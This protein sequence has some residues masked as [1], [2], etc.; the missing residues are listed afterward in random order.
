M[1]GADPAEV[2]VAIHAQRGARRLLLCCDFDGTLVEFQPDPAAVWLPEERRALLQR[3]VDHP[4]V[5]VGIIS[6]RRLA[7]IRERTGLGEP[8]WFAGLH[9]LE[10][11]GGGERFVHPQVAGA[12]ALVQGLS[13]ALS[14]RVTGKPGA[15]I[16]DKDLSVA[17]HFR[18]SPPEIQAEVSAAFEQLTRPAIETGRLRVMRG[19]SV[20]E[21]LPNIPWNKGD[22]VRWI[23]A[24]V[25]RRE[26]GSI[27]PVYFGD[28]VTDQ[29]AFR[30]LEGRGVRIAA[31]DRVSGGDFTVDGPEGITAVLTALADALADS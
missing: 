10:I 4:A 17:V 28:D 22:A 8:A 26:G 18:E 15:F 27:L 25:R 16:E 31:S 13:R 1:F 21:L 23:D 3:L 12:R 6:G 11:E 5:S 19:S 14:P 29:D 9:G 30:E 7:D 24:R 2:A 20:L